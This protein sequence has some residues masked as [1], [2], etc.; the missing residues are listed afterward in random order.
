MGNLP[1]SQG[2]LR[3]LR[4]CRRTRRKRRVEVARRRRRSRS[5]C[6][7]KS[8]S[9]VH[10]RFYDANCKH[11]CFPPSFFGPVSGVDKLA[12]DDNGN[13]MCVHWKRGKKSA[14]HGKTKEV[15]YP[16]FQSHLVNI[17]YGVLFILLFPFWAIYCFLF[18]ILMA[19]NDSSWQ[20]VIQYNFVQWDEKITIKSTLL[21]TPSTTGEF[22]PKT[23]DFHV[24]QVSV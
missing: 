19:I 7:T 2:P 16:H 9:K 3:S 21:Q 12:R 14:N 20:A 10:P 11:R 1:P 6:F 15:Q 17:F 5:A 22:D 23:I 4:G 18:F 24:I 13:K 8:Q